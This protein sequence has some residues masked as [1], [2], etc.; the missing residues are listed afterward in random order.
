ML[1]QNGLKYCSNDYGVLK[2]LFRATASFL[3]AVIRYRRLGPQ[4]LFSQI[5]IVSRLRS[6][7]AE[8]ELLRFLPPVKACVEQGNTEAKMRR[9]KLTLDDCNEKPRNFAS[10]HAEAAAVREFAPFEPLKIKTRNF[11]QG[12]GLNA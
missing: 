6:P 7:E 5:S 1:A 10:P 9:S 8:T 2:K 12:V 11:G 4:D 3:T